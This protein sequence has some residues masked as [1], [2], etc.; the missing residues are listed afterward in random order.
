MNTY[1]FDNSK[2][3]C[4]YAGSEKADAFNDEFENGIRV[5]V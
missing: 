1:V 2:F 4:I 3:K 5:R